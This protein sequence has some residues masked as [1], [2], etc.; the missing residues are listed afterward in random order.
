MDHLTITSGEAYENL[1]LTLDPS[2]NGSVV[3]S[4][5]NNLEIYADQQFIFDADDSSDSYIQ[6]DNTNN[7]IEV[8]VDGYESVRFN[9]SGDGSIDGNGSF[10]SSAFDIAENYPTMN[11]DLEAGDVVALTSNTDSDVSSYLIDRSR[12]SEGTPVLGII[13][14]KPGVVLGGSSFIADF[15]GKVNK[16]GIYEDQARR[17][18]S[19]KEK[20]LIMVPDYTLSAIKVD[21]AVRSLLTG[22]KDAELT[23]DQYQWLIGNIN[24]Y[25]LSSAALNNID[26][27][28]M[29]CKAL[30]QVP[31]ALS[32][33]VPVK[34]DKSNG[35]IK[36]GD[37][38]TASTANEGKASKAVNSGWVIGRALEDQGNSSTVMA[39]VF[40]SWYP[41]G[42]GTVDLSSGDSID[43]NGITANLEIN[44]NIIGYQNLNILGK[45]T[46]T[47]ASVTGNLNVGLISIDGVNNT[48]N[49]VGS[50]L[51]LQD[52]YGAGNIEAF[53]GKLV[54]TTGGDILVDS[55]KISAKEVVAGA[56]TVK[57]PVSVPNLDT[58]STQ[59]EIDT[60]VNSADA[61]VEESS[62]GSAKLTAG[63]TTVQ[64][65]S[66]FVDSN[67]KIFVTP[68]SKTY[69]QSLVVSEK[70]SGAFTIAIEDGVAED[71]NFDYWIVKTE[72]QI[73]ME[74]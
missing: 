20:V 9:A 2:G 73:S 11:D 50:A 65:L 52:A 14:S 39:F 69:G 4:D 43:T 23:D 41:G 38:L 58:L 70:T 61:V 57:V 59:E 54:F 28:V 22:T 53:N 51:R 15:C 66:K 46:L 44:D 49:S 64:I 56:F 24:N 26:D 72:K 35:E 36:A 45:T 16:G 10:D 18:V 25:G 67:S 3:I 37:L 60:A 21:A 32:G 17:E 7:R 30:K 13:S 12:T 71:I 27:K 34:V 1:D 5:G 63:E 68:T 47:N 40:I 29:S 42:S 33:R 74:N 62:I 6:F 19:I 8:Y 48:I 55:G 31:V